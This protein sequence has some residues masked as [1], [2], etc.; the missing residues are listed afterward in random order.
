L[1]E[2]QSAEFDRDFNTAIRKYWAAISIANDEAE[3]W[4]RL[5]RAYLVDGQLKNAETTALE[6]VR[7]AP[8]EVAYT[9]DYLR[10]AQRSK[11]PEVFLSDLQTAYARFPG[12]PEITL[13][14]ARA[15]ERISEE[16]MTA[17]DLYERFVAIAP[18]HPL[19]PEARAAIA[20]LP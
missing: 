10:V 19:V 12:S 8:R 16:L 5:A 9:L 7:L 18:N 1:D 2:A 15:H 4:N 14:L 6:A 20:R 17:R 13:S 11:N 3:V